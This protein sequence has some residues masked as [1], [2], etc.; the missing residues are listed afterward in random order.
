MNTRLLAPLC[1]RIIKYI[2]VRVPANA[3]T[4]LGS[5]SCFIAFLL[6]SGILVGPMSE[7]APDHPWVFGLACVFVFI[8]QVTDSLDGLQARRNG[9]SGPL[10]E[11]LD[12]WLD[13]INA[14]TLPLGIAL[15]FPVI[16]PV[17]V[18]F[19]IL[20][21]AMADWLTGRSVLK[22]GMME[23]GPIG[24]E[25]GLSLVSLFLLS[26]WAF[27]YHFWSTPSE[28]TGFPP[29]WLVYSIVPLAYLFITVSEIEYVAGAE[30]EFAVMITVL[31]PMLVWV[32]VGSSKDGV[33]A[34]LV[35]GLSM[36]GAGAYFAGDILRDRLLGL[37]YNPRLHHF[38]IADTMLL[39]S[40]TPGLPSWAPM[41]SA[42]TALGIVVVSLARQFEQTVGRVHLV[43]GR[44]L[45]H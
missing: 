16:P 9:S 31:L 2:P 42:L 26:F 38:L 17:I 37:E 3:I 21:F 34:L 23:F 10:G 15:A 7:F 44:G 20:I 32:L 39:V 1:R 27:G 41:M 18:V 35:G 12:H 45:F 19:G 29:I 11:F 33:N 4:L 14:F 28:A 43:T 24:G 25:E 13:S 22:R 8:Y 40:L 36:G 5:I 30:K 6:L